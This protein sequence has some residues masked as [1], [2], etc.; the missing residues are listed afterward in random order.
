MDNFKLKEVRFK[1][2]NNGGTLSAM[3]FVFHNGV[4]TPLFQTE[5]AADETRDV[6]QVLKTL[7]VEDYEE[8]R[9]VQMRIQ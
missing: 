4:E 7:P 9:Y 6:P 3:Q 5:G 1:A 8:I 2:V